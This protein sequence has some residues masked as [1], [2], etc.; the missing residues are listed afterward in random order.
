MRYNFNFLLD[1]DG[2]VLYCQ[3]MDIS[4]RAAKLAKIFN[5][6]GKM[7]RKYGQ[8]NARK[9]E[10]RMSVL[11]A[12]GCLDEVPVRKPD[13]C[14][15]LTGK[16]KIQFAVDLEHPFRLVFCP[17]HNPIPVKEGGGFDLRKITAITII[18]VED[19]H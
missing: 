2:I 15:Q 16:R 12:A 7:A 13:R 9:I 11:E 17:N 14:H 3:F 1:H 19:Y 6:R 10:F 4:F 5:S 8:K 18:T